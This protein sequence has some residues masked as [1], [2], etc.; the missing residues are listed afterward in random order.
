[1]GISWGEIGFFYFFSTILLLLFQIPF[2]TKVICIAIANAFAVPYILFSIYYQWRV[3]KRWC[4]LCLTVQAALFMELAWSFINFWDSPLSFRLDIQYVYLIILCIVL[5]IL[6]WY[7]LKPFFKKAN[8]ANI[9]GAAYKRLQNNPEIFT[10]LLEQQTKAPDG[11]Q[12]LGINIGNPNAKNTIIKVCNPYCKPCAIMHSVL[13]EIINNNKNVQLK[14]IFKTFGNVK[15]KDA[16]IANHLMAIAGNNNSINIQ[17]ALDDWYMAKQKDYSA[18]TRKYGLNR[19][20]QKQH[21]K[22]EAMSDWCREA[23][24]PYT[25]TIFVNGYRLP[26]NYD[27]KELKNI[28]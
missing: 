9:Y 26:E 11:W 15:D 18:F 23:E 17:H 25:P 12:N 3:I 21:A 27:V 7:W 10:G 19:E 5:P 1:M 20:L 2:D 22:L 14:I 4:P 16:I 28:L 6:S 13:E 8:A 24:I